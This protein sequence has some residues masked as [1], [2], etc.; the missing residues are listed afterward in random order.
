MKKL[1]YAAMALPLMFAS[2]TQDEI[3]SNDFDSNVP[4]NAIKGLKLGLEKNAV[5]DGVESRADW[6]DA[7]TKLTF[8][9][10]DKVSVYW[11]GDTYTEV[12]H[13]NNSATAT[14]KVYAY[15]T[16]PSAAEALY[17]QFNTVFTTPD[18]GQTV[19]T[20]SMVFEGGNIAVF[21]ANTSFI[22]EGNLYLN[23]SATQGATVQ[24]NIP[25][26]SNQ[27]YI[28]K[29]GSSQ[30]EQLPGYYGDGDVLYAPLKQAANVVNLTLNLSNIPVD[31]NF[32]VQSVELVAANAVFT[33]K[34]QI[35][36]LALTPASEKEVAYTNSTAKKAT[37]ISQV[38]STPVNEDLTTTLKS[39]ALETVGNKVI[40]RFVVLPTDKTPTGASYIK[41]NTNCGYILLTQEAS[42]L[43]EDAIKV[44]GGSANPTGATINTAFGQFV[45]S[46]TDDREEAMFE[47][48]N[49]GKVM[50]RSIA[51][52]VNK[53]VLTGSEVYSSADIIRYAE[54]YKSM[55]KADT[56]PDL[57]LVL[58]SEKKNNF[59]PALT[60]EAVETFEGLKNLNKAATFALTAKSATKANGGV[61]NVE[62]TGGG[63]VFD[64]KTLISAVAVTLD[65]SAEWTMNDKFAF[66]TAAVT[67]QNNG[68]LTINGTKTNSTQNNITETINNNGTIK[69][70][71]NN[72]LQVNG[73]LSTTS[74]SIINVE[75][76]Q[77]LY[78]KSNIT[79]GLY[80]TINIKDAS[81]FLT[82]AKSVSVTNNGTIN[83]YGTI[84]S[85]D[86]SS[87]AGLVNAAYDHD[88][89]ATTAKIGGVINVMDADA[90]TYVYD[91]T[92]G[93][94]VMSDR[95]NEIQ[96]YTGK[97]GKIQYNYTAEDG[98]NFKLRA[99]DRFTY[100][101]FASDVTSLTLNDATNITDSDKD[102]LN[103]A[104]ISME[105]T[106]TTTLKSN[107]V[108]IYN[109]HV[110]SGANLR[111][112]SGNELT[113]NDLFNEGTITIGGTIN[114][115][116]VTISK[117]GFVLSMGGAIK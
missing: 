43:A 117:E 41:V 91:N 42:A 16:K 53:A 37:L 46:Y 110:A 3:L 72:V 103:P 55:G 23:V 31:K 76:G 44:M 60:K 82:V 67:L 74:T 22:N 100:V 94:I 14:Q 13:D 78:F 2:C 11:L 39:T 108:T 63:E 73:A 20:Q 4:N 70:G 77:N 66:T 68:I 5:I 19:T 79:T 51:V 87:G 62:V 54:L 15:A 96:V 35:Q 115:N 106:G 83:N 65:N 64:I 47:G 36:R 107:Q 71:G 12:D 75:A 50:D 97:E 24:D 25:Y 9:T 28:K 86:L 56:D 8:E 7:N 88:A 18:E 17:G 92:A 52:D 111:V 102:I 114:V 26:V 98:A 40:A 49:M 45:D 93:T 80:G 34:S 101:K 69:I 10:N 116:E 109:L 61:T 30:T 58:A 1:F 32:E 85:V 104:E 105:F 89:D 48:E 57:T 33:E 95:T 99:A 113:V 38:W 90:I 84:A 29:Y 112:L 59:F 21:P 6:N 27:L 81:S